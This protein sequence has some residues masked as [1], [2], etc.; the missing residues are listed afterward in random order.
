MVG[1][2][3]ASTAQNLA[4]AIDANE[5]IYF[6][7]I[8]WFGKL[9]GAIAIVDD[10]LAVCSTVGAPYEVHLNRIVQVT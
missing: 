9:K 3:T 5:P 6:I 4:N 8:G 7:V 2:N 10:R 1:S